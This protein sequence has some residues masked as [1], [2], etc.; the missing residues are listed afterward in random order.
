VIVVF[1]L[2][3]TREKGDGRIVIDIERRNVD[4]LP[5]TLTLPEILT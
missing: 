2:T 5:Q 4:A 3:T 1:E